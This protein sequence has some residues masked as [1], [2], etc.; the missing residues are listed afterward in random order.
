MKFMLDLLWL[1]VK[2]LWKFATQG[3]STVKQA[4][5]TWDL[6][7]EM[8]RTEYALVLR[9]R[10]AQEYL[11]L[12]KMTKSVMKITKMFTERSFFCSEYT[13]LE[14]IHMSQYLNMLKIKI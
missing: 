10:L 1:G 13:T 9:E 2:D 12:K 14:K 11:S 6:F 5:M 3:I 7:S 8:F 4:I